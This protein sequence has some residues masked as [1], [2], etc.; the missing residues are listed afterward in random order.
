MSLRYTQSA[1]R[2][3]IFAC[4]EFANAALAEIMDTP[5]VRARRPEPVPGGWRIPVTRFPM[6]RRAGLPE[7]GYIA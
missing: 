6:N 3:K 2:A 7:Y 4:P 5:R 1:D